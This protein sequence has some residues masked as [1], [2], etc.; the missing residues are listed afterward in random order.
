MRASDLALSTYLLGTYATNFDFTLSLSGEFSP[1]ARTGSTPFGPPVLHYPN[2][3]G[4]RMLDLLISDYTVNTL[5]Y[6]LHRSVF[7]KMFCLKLSS[8]HE[9]IRPARARGETLN[10]SRHSHSLNAPFQAFRSFATCYSPM[11]FP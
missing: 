8:V 1:G 4:A 10:L 6:Q 11:P 7:R 2:L 5:L 3:Y 9:C